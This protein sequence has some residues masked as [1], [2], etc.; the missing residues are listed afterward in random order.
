MSPKT[1]NPGTSPGPLRG[2]SD[3]LGLVAEDAM[4]SIAMT[5]FNI[6]ETDPIV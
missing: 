6:N 2:A 4:C 5:E 3:E 1:E